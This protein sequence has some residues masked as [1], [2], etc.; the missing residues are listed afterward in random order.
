MLSEVEDFD[1]WLGTL[2]HPHKVVV[3]GNHDSIMDPVVR[4]MVK[5]A[6]LEVYDAEEVEK[7][8]A[9]ENDKQLLKNGN[10]LINRSVVIHGL[11]IFGSPH[12]IY[13]GQLARWVHN[14]YVYS[15]GH[16]DESCIGQEVSQPESQGCDILV[17]HSPPLGIAD[18]THRHR[19]IWR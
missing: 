15:F 8:E 10:V 5:N 13:N 3:P 14:K 1:N 12:T 4:R 7:W 6:E 2:P 17:T 18:M 9:L 16:T 11:K 19:G